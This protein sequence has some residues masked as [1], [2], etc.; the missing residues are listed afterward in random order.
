MIRTLSLMLLTA[1]ILGL[2]G[3]Q[4]CSRR[5]V[6]TRTTVVPG[7]PYCPPGIS[8][9][10][11][12]APLVP[13]AAV[14]SVQPPPSFPGPGA[15]PAITPAPLGSVPVPPPPPM[16][17]IPAAP[18]TSQSSPRI[19]PNWQPAEARDA[20]PQIAQA[21]T[22]PPTGTAP[23]AST[24]PPAGTAPPNPEPRRSLPPGPTAP[25]TPSPPRLYPP[26]IE[27]QSTA[28]PPLFEKTPPRLSEQ[29]P[30][31]SLPVGIAQFVPAV[32][33]LTN[34]SAGQ[35][36]QIDDGLDWL[37]QHGYKTV[38]HLRT[39]DEANAADRR[40]VEKLG[41][42]YISLAVSPKLTPE[43][44]EQ[45]AKIV[46]DVARRPLFVYDQ[47]GALAGAMWYLYF[48]KVS[49]NNDDQARVR[50]E[51]LGLR[52]EGDEAHRQMWLAVQRVSARSSVIIVVYSE[53]ASR[54]P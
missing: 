21:G 54:A 51:R 45:F 6:A 13:G 24:A 10:P 17:A 14:P 32:A 30:A 42:T 3:C 40:Q 31:T 46:G 9:P 44:V 4:C 23:P 28:E 33:G 50:A 36:P 18:R 34:V 12:P 15:A 53:L 19:E 11:A 49:G 35:R 47:D 5:P 27:Q 1:A 41:M 8:V 2:A 29:K 48:R 20:T 38:L 7:Q 37:A 25:V 39:P 52:T 22:A 43:T 26:E 16:P